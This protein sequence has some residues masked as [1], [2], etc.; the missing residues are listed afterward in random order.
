MDWADGT[1]CA[2]DTETTGTDT[3]TDRIVT[4]TI[5]VIDTTTGTADTTNWLADPGIDIPAEATAVHGITTEHARENGTDAVE[6]VTEITRYLA[7]AADMGWPVVIY[8]APYDLT[9]LD[10]ECRRRGVPTLHDRCADD[11][12]S[13][14]VVDP[15]VI[16]KALDRYRKGSRKLVDVCAAYGI[17]L[18]DDEAHTSAGDALAAA[19]LAWKLTRVFPEAYR[20]LDELQVLQARWYREQRESFEQYL[21]RRKTQDGASADEIAAVRLNR[22]WPMVPFVAEQ[23]A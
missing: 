22:D 9:V 16:D 18:T 19:R 13:L 20:E 7:D 17:T 5:S 2:F 15:L 1:L 21:I 10:R 23:V 14:H 6:V 12:L 8:N 11:N 4:A 3:E